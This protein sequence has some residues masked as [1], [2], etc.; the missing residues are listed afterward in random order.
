MRK[1]ASTLSSKGQITIP[2][3]VRKYLGIK[4]GDKLSFVI[5]DEGV[6]RV[7]VPRYRKV[8]DLIGAAGSLK[9][10]M[11]WEEMRD[12]AREDHVKEIMKDE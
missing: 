11:S 6:V 12:I 7:V 9:K 8:G 1:I 3:E 4:Q 5:E 2:V 10:P